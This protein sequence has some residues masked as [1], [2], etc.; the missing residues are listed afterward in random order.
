MFNQLLKPH[1]YYSV[2]AALI[3]GVILIKL[4]ALHVG[5]I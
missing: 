4:I 2:I 3:R 5:L 1:S